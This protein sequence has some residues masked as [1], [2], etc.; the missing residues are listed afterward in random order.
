M[1]RANAGFGRMAPWYR[2]LEFL[3]FG[4]DLERARFAF[5]ERLSGCSDILLLGEGDGRCAARLATIAPQAR[6]LCVDSSPGMIESARRRIGDNHRVSFACADVR[7]FSID[8]GRFDAVTTL[9]LLD[10]FDA[11]DVATV[12]GRVGGALKPGAL[13][14]FADFVLPARG[15]ARA[16]ARVWLR[17]L[18][19]FFRWE[20]GLAVS[21]LPP[22]EKI[23][24]DEGWKVAEGRDLQC[25]LLR[26]ALLRR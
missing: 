10:C 7:T 23:L 14:L 19:T 26:T 5:L 1:S 8:P 13:W 2:A 4:G 12:V 17:V 22:S 15:L 3:A 21:S 18:Y 24:A 25:G 6:I 11:A 16:R 20:T 9:F